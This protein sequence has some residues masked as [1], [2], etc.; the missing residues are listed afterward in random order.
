M[1]IFL[2]ARFYKRS[3]I[4]RYIEGLYNGIF[5]D[6]PDIKVIAAGDANLLNNSFLK[7]QQ[8]VP[9][10]S[11]IYSLNEQVKGSL[12]L[13]RFKRS[14]DIFHIPH[15]NAPWF[16]PKNS[17]VT[18]HDLTQFLF[19]EFFGRLKHSVAEVV[20][21][22]ALKKAGRII[23][24][25]KSTRKD[26]VNHYPEIEDKVR[27]VYNG[28][29]M[30]FKP[31]PENE[32]IA[33]KKDKGIDDYILYVGNRKQTKN[34][35]RLLEAFSV[36]RKKYRSLQ[37]III[38]QRFSKVDE[39]DVWKR[40][41]DLNEDAVKKVMQISD[42]ELRWYY[43]GARLLIHPSLYEGFGFTPLEAMACGCPAIV[44][45]TS[46]LPEVCGDAVLY[47]D[48]HDT[49]DMV[50]KINMVLEGEDL[51]R[52]LIDK[53]FKQVSFFTWEKCAGKTLEIFTEVQHSERTR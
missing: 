9:Y 40:N 52:N 37:L 20:L 42:E 22:N 5:A 29:S 31:L 53:G 8:V 25:S 51:R 17:V 30:D 4:G 35:K 28:I 44:S 43:C 50:K 18:V 24:V 27:M 26:L 33:F 46:S 38:G 10:S 21:R 32:V 41:N 19:P 11:H 36:I 15:Y 23:V 3:G 48:P 2:D 7:A 16:L 45:N 39:V 12:L 1:N 47:F 6:S 14:V 49:S 13:R 34:L